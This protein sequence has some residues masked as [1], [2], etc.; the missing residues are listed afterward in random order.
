MRGIAPALVLALAL[1]GCG[2]GDDG[3]DVT[4]VEDLD[5][6]QAVEDAGSARLS[7][8][9]D[10]EV[11]GSGFG[12]DEGGPG[13][14]MGGTTLMTGSAEGLFAYPGG[15]LEMTGTTS[16]GSP[17]PEGAVDEPLP[18]LRLELEGRRVGGEDFQRSWAAGEEPGPWSRLP[19]PDAADEEDG[20]D[21]LLGGGFPGDPAALLG[22]VR[23]AARSFTE[24]GTEEVRGDAVT[25]Y[26]AE[27]D[28]EDVDGGLGLWPGEDQSVSI[29]VWVDGE[30]RLRRL[31]AGGLTLE[32]WDFGVP[33]EVAVPDD[34]R[35]VEE[36]DQDM[37]DLFAEVTGEWSEQAA[38]TTAGTDWTVFAAPATIRGVPT[39]CRTLETAEGGLGGLG[40]MMGE[41][42]PIPVHG[43]ALATCGGGSTFGAV[44]GAA[45]PDPSVQV[46][47]SLGLSGPSLVGFVVAE[48]HAADGIRLVLDGADPVD[49]EVDATGVAVW[50]PTDAPAVLAV[51]LD[52]GAVSCPPSSLA[53][54]AGGGDAAAAL[55][56]GL[57]ACV[58]A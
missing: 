46:L 30:D 34:V 17:V 27:V 49:L 40:G 11:P 45:F 35:P 13:E 21:G 39:T 37:P 58:A 18:P 53:G 36:I 15:D 33:V 56:F 2:R 50:D 44:V 22:R 47:T 54:A 5:P 25:R 48:R 14:T 26:R 23:D 28:R 19:A 9:V 1:T 3:E 51:E 6:L 31:A 41:Q 8:E 57:D 29:D 42:S 32:L 43:D 52:G 38:G 24:V 12:A 16:F 20:D 55:V 7:L 4:V 10:V